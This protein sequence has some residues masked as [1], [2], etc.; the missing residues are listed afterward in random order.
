MSLI[1]LK[2]TKSYLSAEVNS[3]GMVNIIGASAEYK[4]KGIPC[5]LL[6]VGP[7]CFEDLFSDEEDSSAF[8]T[9]ISRCSY[10]DDFNEVFRETVVEL[11]ESNMAFKAFAQ[12]L[13]ITMDN[14]DNLKD[15][16]VRTCCARMVQTYDSIKAYL[17]GKPVYVVGW[18][19]GKIIVAS[20]NQEAMDEAIKS[21]REEGVLQDA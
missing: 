19:D 13:F 11:C 4:D 10:C 15:C 5:F 2:Y 21:I 7:I 14:N 1:L 3:S 6:D 12:N 20:K 16:L 18:E 9:I 17:T 8:A